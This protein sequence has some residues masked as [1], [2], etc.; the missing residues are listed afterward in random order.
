MVSPPVKVTPSVDVRSTARTAQGPFPDPSPALFAPM[1][2]G[3]F[4][5]SSV[6][7][8]GVVVLGA[9]FLEFADDFQMRLF[10]ERVQVKVIFLTVR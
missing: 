6:D 10:P 9:S 1:V 2:M 7:E 4:S 3:T 5:A 8:I